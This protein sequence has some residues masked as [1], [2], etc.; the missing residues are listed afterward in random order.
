M[1]DISGRYGK[2]DRSWV[3]KQMRMK[4]N[5]NTD[6]MMKMYIVNNLA[7]TYAYLEVSGNNKF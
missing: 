5:P 1:D 3:K 4:D 7:Q 6:G 2:M